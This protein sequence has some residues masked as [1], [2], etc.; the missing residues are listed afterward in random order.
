MWLIISS[1]V[2]T[3]GKKYDDIK[4]LEEAVVDV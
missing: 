2:F 4:Y 1:N 3:R